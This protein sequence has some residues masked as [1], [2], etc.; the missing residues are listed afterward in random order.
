MAG[1]QA[2]DLDSILDEFE[3]KQSETEKEDRPG[4]PE[5][6]IKD[7]YNTETWSSHQLN[8]NKVI[9]FTIKTTI[10]IVSNQRNFDL[11]LVVNC[12]NLFAL[13][14]D[15][16]GNENDSTFES[17]DIQ[18]QKNDFA[19]EVSSDK[20][21]DEQYDV[22]IV[23][24][25]PVFNNRH[26]TPHPTST[27]SAQPDVLSGIENVIE[28]E[29]KTIATHEYKE[30]VDEINTVVL[31]KIISSNTLVAHEQISSLEVGVNKPNAT[32]L[33]PNSES[34]QSSK[35]QS[36]PSFESIYDKYRSKDT[37]T[38]DEK[39]PKDNFS[40]QELGNQLGPIH[41]LDTSI[42]CKNSNRGDFPIV[43][44]D[45]EM[46]NLISYECPKVS[47]DELDELLQQLDSTIIDDKAAVTNTDITIFTN[48]DSEGG[49]RPKNIDIM[50]NIASSI[51]PVPSE[52]YLS[53]EKPDYDMRDKQPDLLTIGGTEERSDLLCA[54]NPS[55]FADSY[56]HK[57]PNLNISEGPITQSNKDEKLGRPTSLDLEQT[58][59]TY[60]ICS[61]QAVP[62]DES[63][64]ASAP[65]IGDCE[66]TGPTTGA[67]KTTVD[68]E[69]ESEHLAPIVGPPGSTP[70][71]PNGPN[72][73]GI[74]ELLQGMTEEQ[75]M[76][77][78]VSPFW[79]PD[80]EALTCMICD[81]KFT[82]VKRRH[83][84]RACGKVLC[85]AC[86]SE[87]FSL[88]CLEGKEG[89]VCTPC[90]GILD[91]LQRVEQMS[92]I[93]GVENSNS[94]SVMNATHHNIDIQGDQSAS[95]AF[96]QISN[97][98]EASSGAM[99]VSVLKRTDGT[100]GTPIG[101][102]SI[103]GGAAASNEAKQVMFSDGIRPGGDL[104]ELDGPENIH[105]HPKRSGSKGSS[106]KH[107]REHRE[108]SNGSGSSDCPLKS[109]HKN[110]SN[111]GELARSMI[112]IQ[113]LPYVSG[114]G[115]VDNNILSQRFE[116]GMTIPF[117]LNR[118]LR[119]YVTLVKCYSPIN[120]PLWN[121][122]TQ[123]LSSVGQDELVILLV[124]NEGE[125]TPSRSIF[126]H[127]QHIYEQ[128]AQ[129]RHFS[130]MDHS[131]ISGKEFL[132]GTEYGGF[133]YIRHTFQ[134]IDDLDLPSQQPFLF[135]ILLTKWEMPWAR[136]FPLRL[137]LRLGAECRYYP[138][139]LWSI[140]A[141]NT[142]YKEIGNTIMKLLSVSI[143]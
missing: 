137:L 129:G 21:Q 65:I 43:G 101:A 72:I 59:S 100:A 73:S 62:E 115:P 120:K 74:P 77:G 14:C 46:N 58:P 79:I 30:P 140:R 11:N 20:S 32:F 24:K 39:V 10:Q 38:D 122:K 97:E 66:E 89:R 63:Y 5:I 60:D 91:R 141:R 80:T 88:S 119:V 94:L 45:S 1:F 44:T 125:L 40:S 143:S 107:R 117:S 108:K 104:T 71:N 136:V 102:S 9:R 69:G 15:S 26:E 105:R 86:C 98:I 64:T 50:P 85:T 17:P 131:V 135:G 133:L 13:Q 49:A 82:M 34:T 23:K 134:C 8:I 75:L 126:D 112:P 19:L 139:P 68:M 127:F 124:Q 61:G 110:N 29:E 99:P 7:T 128:A 103:A 81:A 33:S 116:Q 41:L 51:S 83:H 3:S 56:S 123:G 93:A 67:D 132:E 36:S 95:N 90:K 12:N 57:P 76:L 16:Y 96:G 138:S 35:S 106:R 53:S 78:K 111:T 109:S 18:T 22:E 28:R 6:P 27:L 70:A 84:C 142:V 55:Q 2:V 121:Y 87:K 92:V 42:E 130:N 54:E 37:D 114:Q 31:N 25:E 48:H 113:G 52:I 118:N 47:S 4:K